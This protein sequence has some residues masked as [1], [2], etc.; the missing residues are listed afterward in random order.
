MKRFRLCDLPVGVRIGLI[1]LVLTLGGGL[2]ASWYYMYLHYSPRDGNK[3]ELSYVDVASAY[4][5]MKIPAPL[6]VALERDHP[7]ELTDEDMPAAEREA[8]LKW[9]GGEASSIMRE[10]ENEALEELMP[11]DIVFNRCVACHDEDPQNAEHPYPELPLYT[12]AEVQAVAI[13]RDIEPTPERILAASTHAHALALA[14]QT[15]LVIGLLLGTRLPRFVVSIA[16]I[17]LGFGL[18]LD[19]GSWWLAR[20]NEVYVYVIFGAGGVFNSISA[21]SLG[22]ILVD[23]LVPRFKRVE[24][25]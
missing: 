9:L 10:F 22:L 5:K 23:L 11:A 13:S 8:L 15:M 2:I 19:V 20:S 25:D 6:I 21:L 1:G 24:S 17:L 14:V 16:A 7:D 3:E 4:H 18:L 12:P